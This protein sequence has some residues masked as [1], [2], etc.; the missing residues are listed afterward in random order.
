MDGKARNSLIVRTSIIG[1]IANVFLAGFKAFVG[2]MANSIAVVLD[3]VNNITDALSSI[4]TIVGAKLSAK[5]PDKKHPLGYGRIEYLS[6]TIV[7]GIILYAGI[8]A[9]VESIKS[10]INPTPPEYSTL[11]IVIISV[12]VAVKIVLGLFVQARGKKAKSQAL[13]AS[14]KDALF[15]AILSFSVLVSAIIYLLSGVSLEAYVGVIIAVI[16]IKAGIEMMIETLNELLGKREDAELVNR[17]KDIVKSQEHVL[18]AYDLVLHNYGPNKYYGS[19]HIELPDT[20][21][22]KDTDMIIRKTEALV[23]KET[24]VILTG[25]SIY[26]FNTEDKDAIEIREKIKEK[27]LSYEWA[28]QMHGFYLDREESYIRFDVVISFGM[29]SDKAIETIKEDMKNLY[30]EYTFMIIADADISLSE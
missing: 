13:V 27:V 23:Y 6:A 9:M 18:G 26:S 2:L 14:G 15:D 7:A 8:T 22:V 28:L 10:I 20:M 30:P 16:I 19:I 4:I 25:I 5:R 1:I 11:T 21:T 17:I 29:K 3:A 24:G 12:A